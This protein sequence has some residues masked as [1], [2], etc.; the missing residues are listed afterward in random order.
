MIKRFLRLPLSGGRRQYRRF[1]RSRAG[2]TLYI[3]ILLA[4]GL[5]TVI[6]LFYSVVTSLKP[7]EEL[8]VFPPQFM[9]RRPTWINYLALPSIMDNL[10]VP[11]SRYVFNS[12]FV[13]VVTTLAHV[14]IA[15]MAAFVLSKSNLKFCRVLFLIVQ[16]SLLYNAYTLETPRYLIYSNLSIID[17]YWVYILPMI[18]SA[19]G[20]FL[21]KQYMD[22][23]IP[24]ALM[25]AAR[26][27][28][29]GNVRIFLRIVMPIVKPA[30]LTL[31]LFA[32]RD[33]WSMQPSGTIFSEE[34]KTLPYAAAAVGI[35][36]I[37]RAGSAMAITVIM[38]IP[39]I[40]VYILSQKSVLQTMS[41]SGIK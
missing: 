27:D 22:I 23:S 41:S 32:F 16:F 40:L 1:T 34:L 11:L 36:G 3:L 9:V 31:A 7:I 25:E 10:Y 35:G 5:F 14:L 33:S 18:P 37:A 30:W 29:A 19:M 26:I 8:L 6:P 13:S 24:S 20:V 4:A 2:N 12:V 17:T 15:S 21:M 39:P 38:M 28:G